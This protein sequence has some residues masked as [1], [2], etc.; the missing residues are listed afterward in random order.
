[1]Y[2]R[3]LNLVNFKNY[4]QLDIEL[5][6]KINCFVGD[7]GAGK[8]NL[9][10][11]VY[12]LSLTKS[13]F[14]TIDTQNITNGQDFF[15]IQ[16]EYERDGTKENIYCG[17]AKDKRKQ[18]KRNNKEYQKLSLHVGLIP[19]VMISPADSSLIIEG[20]DVRRKFINGVISQYSI[21]YLD[22]VIRYN[23]ALIQRNILLKDF[24]RTGTFNREYLEVW[25]A[26]LIDSGQFIYEKRLEFA[27][28]FQPIFQSYYKTISES[29]EK[30]GLVYQSQLNE[31]NFK[32]LLEKSLEKD[33]ILQYTTVGIHKDD[34]LMKMN[35]FPI[36]RN[37]SQGQQ[38]TYLVALKFAEFDFI[39]ELN[40]I[41]PVLLL[42]D[43]F[44]KFDSKRVRQ[45]ISLVSDKHFGQIFITDT[46]QDR[47]VSIL[48]E[49]SADHK[50]FRV[51]NGHITAINGKN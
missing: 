20:S 10:D 48:K 49:I 39:K 15:M 9:L 21:E 43:I 23:R 41:A 5:C 13:Y 14:N 7:N 32:Q 26:Q 42:D 18:F 44:D 16:G 8:T 45:I 40:G 24:G 3:K 47:A 50:V 31:G 28:K 19:V 6:E 33:R 46:N 37:G 2:L 1:M 27:R 51:E 34:L 29:Q 35:S 12:Y 4:E 17:V 30:V 36:K 22:T 25:D 11:A 38:K